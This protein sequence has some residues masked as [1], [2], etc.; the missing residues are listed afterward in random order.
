MASGLRRN[1]LR[2]RDQNSTPDRGAPVEGEITAKM[3]F[4][5]VRSAGDRLRGEE[6]ARTPPGKKLD[7]MGGR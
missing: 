4:F 2:P 3:H 1:R 6:T 7:R 5:I